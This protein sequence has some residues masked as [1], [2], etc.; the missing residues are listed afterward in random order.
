MF[1]S[2]KI[3]SLDTLHLYEK[4]LLC[5]VEDSKHLHMP[6]ACPSFA[7]HPELVE[8]DFPTLQVLKH[9]QGF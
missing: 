1:L 5:H 9:L 8:G 4:P 6:F 7:G 2:T 3:K